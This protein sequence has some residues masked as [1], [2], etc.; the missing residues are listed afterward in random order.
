MKGHTHYCEIAA[1]K[2]T[3]RVRGPFGVGEACGSPAQHKLLRSLAE[4][5]S[6]MI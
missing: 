3:Y 4:A 2:M 6:Q 5:R 1:G